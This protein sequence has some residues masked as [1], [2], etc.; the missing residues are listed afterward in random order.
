MSTPAPIRK[1][2]KQPYSAHRRSQRNTTI[3]A[4]GANTVLGL[5]PPALP[6]RVRPV[7][8]HPVRLYPAG[9]RRP[10][11]RDPNS[12]RP[13]LPYFINWARTDRCAAATDPN[14]MRLPA[15]GPVRL[16]LGA[17]GAARWRGTRA[18]GVRVDDSSLPM[19]AEGDF[20]SKCGSLI[21]TSSKVAVFI[22]TWFSPRSEQHG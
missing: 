14:G 2:A 19:A 7:A 17:P 18:G 12:Y 5:G 6:P 1:A 22:L 4:E 11:A 21:F 9:A 15:A 20:P 16:V 10:V 3:P 13:P 8:G